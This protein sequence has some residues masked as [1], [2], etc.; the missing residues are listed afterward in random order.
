MFSPQDLS[1]LS[2]KC[3]RCNAGKRKVEQNGDDEVSFTNVI[4][5]VGYCMWAVEQNV[6]C[7]EYPKMR[8]GGCV[9]TMIAGEKQSGRIVADPSKVSVLPAHD[10]PC[11]HGLFA[12]VHSPAITISRSVLK[13]LRQVGIVKDQDM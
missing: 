4:H 13:R 10:L 11:R 9:S 2:G 6:L 12:P 8:L 1:R 3:W 5:E 7:N